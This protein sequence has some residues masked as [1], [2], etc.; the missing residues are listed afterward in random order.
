[1]HKILEIYDSGLY[2]IQH[3]GPSQDIKSKK[4]VRCRYNAVSF[5]QNSHNR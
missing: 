4:T 5:L 1:M 3:V 2:V